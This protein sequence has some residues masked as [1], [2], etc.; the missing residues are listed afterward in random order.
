MQLEKKIYCHWDLFRFLE[1]KHMNEGDVTISLSDTGNLE[2]MVFLAKKVESEEY[3]VRVYK[4]KETDEYVPHKEDN[5]KSFEE[6]DE[7][8]TFIFNDFESARD[9]VDFLPYHHY[10]Y[11]T[12]PIRAIEKSD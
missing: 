4:Y 5:I 8:I 7:Y 10:E 1:E 12:R 2:L 11:K 6:N 9:F 3:E